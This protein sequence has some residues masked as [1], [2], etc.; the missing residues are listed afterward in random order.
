MSL[1]SWKSIVVLLL[2]MGVQILSANGQSSEFTKL[3]AGYEQALTK[4]SNSCREREKHLLGSYVQGLD[5]GGS[6]SQRAPGFHIS[7]HGGGVAR[8][9]GDGFG[10]QVSYGLAYSG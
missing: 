1:R 8:D 7:G 5:K 6:V 10:F 4:V 9:V 2:F 3:Q